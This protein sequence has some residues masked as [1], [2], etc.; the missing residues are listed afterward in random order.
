MG[1]DKI[2]KI[3]NCIP[4]FRRTSKCIEGKFFRYFLFGLLWISAVCSQRN[5]HTHLAK[6]LNLFDSLV[7]LAAMEKLISV[8]IQDRRHCSIS[9]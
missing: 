9:M 4:L 7:F 1:E 8:R 5:K 3:K 2:F 6:G